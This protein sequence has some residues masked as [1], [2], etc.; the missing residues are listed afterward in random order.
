V[1]LRGVIDRI[2]LKDGTIRIIDYKSGRDLSVYRSIS[3]LFDRSGSKNNKA[4]FQTFLYALMYLRNHPEENLPVVPGLYN[5][6][7][8]H[9]EKF[10]PRIKLKSGRNR[11]A[12]LIEDIRPQ[13]EE[14]NDCLA[15]LIREVF[16]PSVPFRHAEE[17]R[18]C[19]YCRSLGGPSELG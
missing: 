5:F 2:D 17:I 12:E 7:E 15:N 4:V 16:D 13:M 1:G 19:F 14:F 8:L 18:E 6:K 3:E 11:S 9:E 10:D